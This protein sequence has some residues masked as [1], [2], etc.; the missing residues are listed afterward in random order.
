MPTPQQLA[1]YNR[2]LDFAERQVRSLVETHPNFFPMYTVA[3]KWRHAGEKW[4]QWTDGF[5]GGMMWQFVLRRRPKG[6]GEVY[7]RQKAEHY[8]TLLEHRQHDRDVHDLG[9]I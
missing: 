2:A 4:T 3:G 6:E 9:F 5:L 1:A 7:W 8:S